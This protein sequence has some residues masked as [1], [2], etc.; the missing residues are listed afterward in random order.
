MVKNFDKKSTWDAKYVINFRVV[1][2]IGSKQLEVSD[3]IGRTRK[4]YVVMHIR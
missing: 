2:F 1:G 4:V 3:P